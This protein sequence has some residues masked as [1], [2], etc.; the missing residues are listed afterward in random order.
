MSQGDVTPVTLS[1]YLSLKTLLFEPFFLWIK[2]VF[3]YN[4]RLYILESAS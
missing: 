4:T 3:D 1:G 2:G